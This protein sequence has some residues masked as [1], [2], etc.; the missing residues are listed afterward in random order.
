MLRDA[1][2][3]TTFC[4]RLGRPVFGDERAKGAV[5]LG[6]E[7]INVSAG[8]PRRE[9]FWPLDDHRTGIPCCSC[10]TILD[11]RYNVSGVIANHLRDPA[12][13]VGDARCFD[14]V[15]IL[16]TSF[17]VGGLVACNDAGDRPTSI[18]LDKYRPTAIA[19]PQA[20]LEYGC[21]VVGRVEHDFV[22]LALT[23]PVD[24]VRSPRGL[25]LV[26]CQTFRPATCRLHFGSTTRRPQP[27]P[28]RHRRI[29]PTCESKSV[30]RRQRAAPTEARRCRA[31]CG[32][33]RL[34]SGRALFCPGGRKIASTR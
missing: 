11:R 15:A 2:V 20:A 16:R 19:G 9:R 26:S 25:P 27:R 17:F 6:V 28:H 7:R 29:R 4:H 23:D 14:V 5:I 30:T 8:P 34:I 24:T 1:A 22:Q 32:R 33:G 31:C 12:G 21:A 18:L 3:E 10:A 13:I